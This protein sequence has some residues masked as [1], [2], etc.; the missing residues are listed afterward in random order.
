MSKWCDVLDEDGNKVEV[1]VEGEEDKEREGGAWYHACLDSLARALSR[2]H[3]QLGEDDASEKTRVLSASPA[4]NTLIGM[5]ASL[6]SC[7]L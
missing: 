7:W 1:E 3:E 2:T 4:Q 6:S 5:S